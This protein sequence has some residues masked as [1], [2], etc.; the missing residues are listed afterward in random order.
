MQ[1]LIYNYFRFQR[2]DHRT[3][4]KRS[5][6]KEILFSCFH[7]L[8]C[9][10]IIFGFSSC[11]VDQ[12]YNSYSTY[13][14]SSDDGNDENVGTSPDN[15]WKSLNRVNTHTFKPDDR[16]LFKSGTNYKGQLRPNGSGTDEKP[17]IIDMYDG[18][19]KPRIDGE[20][21]FPET[22]L[23]YNVEYWEVNNLEIINLGSKR[24]AGRA[25]VRV[26]ADNFGTM[27]HIHLKDLFVH[28]VNGSNV[29]NDGGG[30]GI[31]WENYGEKVKS[32]FD[33]LLI[34][35]CYLVRTDRDGIKG[36]SG[37]FWRDNWYPSLNVV[38]RGNVLEDIGGDGIVPLGCDG[39][40]IENNII[41]G[42]RT[43]CNDY[44]AGIWPWSCDNTVIQFNEVSGVKGYKDGQGF[45]SD[46]NCRN[47][48]IQYNYSHDNDG[49]FILICDNGE[50]KLPKST[51]NVGTIVRYNI[52]K[53][54]GKRTFHI[55]GPVENTLIYN[56][57]IYIDSE[58][59]VHLFLFTNWH[60]WSNN[61]FVANNIFYVDGTAKYSTEVSVGE[62]RYANG[63]Y[64][65]D[66]GL[67]G[68]KNNN[69]SH[70]LFYGNHINLPEDSNAI[71]TN[72]MFI[73]AGTGA[74]GMES[75][76]GYRLQP[77]SLCI[78]SGLMISNN[79]DKDFFKNNI[80]QSNSIDRGA[81]EFVK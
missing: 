62:K 48:I 11:S 63:T 20:G 66:L 60:G 13:Y 5:K 24:E 8:I 77:G 34:E 41:K 37:Y 19:D 9:C 21:L 6:I 74:S 78:D 79:G 50:S 7:L 49:G 22:I 25:G 1:S 12:K 35:N 38:I 14:I 42:A 16:L 56:N 72:P 68:S 67:G 58:M 44:A 52:S 61:T 30:T 23:L 57:T 29:K 76:T 53:N 32:R 45:D 36:K 3:K 59:D 18:D 54:D 40:I 31:K 47:T 80:P 71:F 55:A 26:V 17:I 75:L 69:F 43:R 73:D 46:Y 2:F 10:N 4:N 51:G 65:T 28:D 27:H 64:K 39:C 33:D 15:A 70:N 81:V